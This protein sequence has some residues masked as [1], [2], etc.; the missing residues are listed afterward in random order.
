MTATRK[1]A[2]SRVPRDSNANESRVHAGTGERLAPGDD[3]RT[4]PRH[5]SESPTK[6]RVPL[7]EQPC[8]ATTRDRNHGVLLTLWSDYRRGSPCPLPGTPA[9]V[10]SVRAREE[11]CDW[12]LAP[13]APGRY[14][15]ASRFAMTGAEEQR[16][17]HRQR[18]RSGARSAPRC[19]LT[20]QEKRSPSMIP[21]GR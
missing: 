19:R 8:R 3:A 12:N 16:E 7:A 5:G 2:G 21:K 18:A 17:C 15:R 4:P 13:S 11:S 20:S 14:A 6:R 1:H 10:A 9:G